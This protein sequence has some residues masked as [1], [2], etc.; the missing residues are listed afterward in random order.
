MKRY[1]VEVGGRTHVVEVEELTAERFHVRVGGHAF[2]LK[3]S[4][5]EEVPAEPVALEPRAA[6]TDVRPAP[7]PVESL[8]RVAPPPLA[9]AAGAGEVRAP[10]PGTVTSV[11][12]RPGDVVRRGQTLVRLEAMKML[13]HVRAARDGVVAEVTAEAGRSVGFGDVLL[14][15][16]PDAP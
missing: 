16:R 14:T 8:P 13:N 2:E 11:E 15:F 9:G 10:M 5:A 7:P 4:R 3:L 1:A 12:V 6:R